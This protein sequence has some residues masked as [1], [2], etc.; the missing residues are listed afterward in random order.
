MSAR[1]KKP[2][3]PKNVKCRYCR[4]TGRVPEL[5]E[6]PRCLGAGKCMVVGRWDTCPR[7]DA[8][9]KVTYHAAED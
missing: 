3:R 9:G 8:T 4:G 5:V 1:L 7:C 6:C 2:G